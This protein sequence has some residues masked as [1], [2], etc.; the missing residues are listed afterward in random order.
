MNRAEKRSYQFKKMVGDA[1]EGKIGG[2]RRVRNR[3]KTASKLKKIL[4]KTEGERQPG[5]PSLTL[6]STRTQGG[7]GVCRIVPYRPRKGEGAEGKAR[8]VT[9]RL[10]IMKKKKKTEETRDYFKGDMVNKGPPVKE[11][12]YRV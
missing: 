7:C 8:P 1:A 9:N 2:L 6:K 10:I 5:S 3:V 11:G 12:G 4:G